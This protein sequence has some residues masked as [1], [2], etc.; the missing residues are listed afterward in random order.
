MEWNGFGGD[1]ELEFVENER[2]FEKFHEERIWVED[3]ATD[4]ISGLRKIL[5]KGMS[6]DFH[7]QASFGADF[8]DV[9]YCEKG[10]D[11]TMGVD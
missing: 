3:D 9:G 6:C 2:N 5:E 7:Y 10:F 4:A 1:C 8:V 11:G